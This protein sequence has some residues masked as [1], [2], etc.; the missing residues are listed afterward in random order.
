MSWNYFIS[1]VYLKNRHLC[2]MT[3]CS[4]WLLLLFFSTPPFCTQHKKIE[5]ILRQLGARVS[6]LLKSLPHHCM[7]VLC[8][9]AIQS[10]IYVTDTTNKNLF[11]FLL[12][13]SNSFFLLNWLSLL[14]QKLV[15]ERMLFKSKYVYKCDKKRSSQKSTEKKVSND[16][17]GNF[18]RLLNTWAYSN[19][20]PSIKHIS[21]YCL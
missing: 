19:F 6:P 18:C 14:R 1:A 15:D 8:I 3:T 7:C 16:S 12:I 4:S 5:K 20:L 17:F 10:I 13:T 9:Q 21:S 2:S 11:P